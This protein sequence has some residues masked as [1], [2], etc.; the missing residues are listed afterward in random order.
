MTSVLS[1]LESDGM[2]AA[3]L[4]FSLRQRGLE[5]L[6]KMQSTGCW[7]QSPHCLFPSQTC[8]CTELW[9]SGSLEWCRDLIKDEAFG[10]PGDLATWVTQRWPNLKLLKSLTRSAQGMPFGESRLQ[11]VDEGEPMLLAA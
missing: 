10:V 6:V 4:N 1:G 5:C 7:S 9:Y 11:P 8:S 2:S 3:D